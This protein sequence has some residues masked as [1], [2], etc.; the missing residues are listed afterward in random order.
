MWRR[1]TKL[2]WTYHPVTKYR[3]NMDGRNH[4]SLKKKERDERSSY[5][6]L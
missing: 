5:E 2:G 6:S 3:Y 1:L 4:L